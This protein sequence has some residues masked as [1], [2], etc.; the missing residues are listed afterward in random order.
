MGNMTDERE[1]QSEL[2]Q[3]KDRVQD[4]ADSVRSGT[5]EQL[6][7]Q[8]DT[9]TTEAGGQVSSTARA[10]R[11]ASEQLR[12]QG[13]DRA[14][15]TVEAVAERG[16]RLGSFLSGAD[17]ERVLREAEDIARRQPWLVAGAGLMLGF[18]A[19]RFVKATSADRYRTTFS[20]RQDGYLPPQQTAVPTAGGSVG[21][22]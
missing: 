2:E 16:E 6:R 13:D 5:R 17:G 9:R 3:V 11:T 20:A 10:F 4:A 8:I 1:S 21:I 19:A 22:G 18:I 12:L 14:A 7:T 15:S